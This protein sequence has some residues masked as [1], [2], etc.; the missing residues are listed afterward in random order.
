MNLVK[1]S[2]IGEFFRVKE[3]ESRLADSILSQL[4]RKQLI[5]GIRPEDIEICSLQK[6]QFKHPVYSVE[7]LGDAT[8]IT[9]RVGHNYITAKV[10]K[11]VRTQIGEDVVMLFAPKRMYFII[12]IVRNC[13]SLMNKLAWQFLPIIRE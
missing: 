11:E 3:I 5:L 12:M 2:L 8:L 6:A 4:N 10:G 13:L 7:M 1:G 9:I